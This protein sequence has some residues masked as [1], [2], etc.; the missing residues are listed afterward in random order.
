MARQ[1]R[2]LERLVELLETYLGGDSR[3]TIK[4]PDSLVDKTTGGLREVDVS[5]R[6]SI[7]SSEILVILECRDRGSPQ[8]VTW[9]EQL[10]TKRDDVGADKAVAVSSSGFSEHAGQKA[11]A[12]NIDLRTID[13]RSIADFATWF[14]PREIV[15]HAR[16]MDVQHVSVDF[17]EDAN[18]DAVQD[19][20]PTTNI[21]AFQLKR[22]TDGSRLSLMQIVE[23]CS[24]E[25]L[26]EGI[27]PD[28]EP[29]TRNL[30]LIVPDKSFVVETKSGDVP[31][32]QL[33]YVLKVK[34]MTQKIP[35][36]FRHYSNEKGTLVQVASAELPRRD[37]K[38][39][40]LNI[41]R[42]ADTGHGQLAVTLQNC[43]PK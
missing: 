9:I 7:G 3:V 2:D 37:G 13:E 18:T 21:T 14:I 8:D 10:A 23:G 40:V 17:L 42:D 27:M 34:I 39:V 22:V 16:H 35:F 19:A 38:T 43:D 4:S 20:M 1:G 25:K 15:S 6:S 11:K 24:H 41:L 33:V 28:A 12:K 36:T 29:I 5:I 31:V 30:V 26:F 32:A